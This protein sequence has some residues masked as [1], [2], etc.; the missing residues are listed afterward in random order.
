MFSITVS[1]KGGDEK[2]LEFDK[3]E[4]TIGRV[5]GNDV[6][7]PKGNVSKRHSRIVLKDGKFIIVDLKST[8][9]TY[10]NGRKITSPL[11]VKG[12]DKIYIG[13]F[14]LAID[15]ASDAPAAAP[16]EE[17]PPAPR[18]AATI[19]PPMPPHRPA[20]PDVEVNG[21]TMMASEQPPEMQQLRSRPNLPLP[22]P[23]PAPQAVTMPPPLAPAAAVART[24]MRETAPINAV[25]E[26]VREPEWA[27]APARPPAPVETRPLQPPVLAAAVPAMEVTPNPGT[28]PI[29]KLDEPESETQQRHEK[30]TAFSQAAMPTP[31][32]PIETANVSR[33]QL[34]ETV[35]QLGSELGD[36]LGLDFEGPQRQTTL[37]LRQRA[38]KAARTLVGQATLPTGIDTDLLARWAV[39]EA[40]GFGAFELIME[41]ATVDELSVGA[42]DRVFVKRQGGWSDAPHWFSSRKALDRAIER[43]VAFGG[44][45]THTVAEVQSV[46]LER[47]FE[48]VATGRAGSAARAAVVRRLDVAPH[49]LEE[50]VTEGWLSV[51]MLEL[52]AKAVAGRRNILVTSAFGN[53]RSTLV[54]ALGA[55][56]GTTERIVALSSRKLAPSGAATTLVRA[57]GATLS[58]AL[59]LVPDRLIVDDI[60]LHE[61]LRVVGLLGGGFDG[62]LLSQQASFP[63][64]AISALESMARLQPSA[65]PGEAIDRA[66]TRG[67]HLLA[68]IDRIGSKFR[69][70]ELSELSADRSL[71]TLFAWQRDSARFASVGA[72]SIIGQTQTNPS[73]RMAPPGVRA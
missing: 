59:A 38:E 37:E 24:A 29:E 17:P 54:S 46:V 42:F 32:V 60:Q 9:G 1:E 52:F 26:A 45:P 47:G 66:I 40:A 68:H 36:R 8:N 16:R 39:A 49:S 2:R 30:I 13:D 23:Q 72:P 43:L 21:S 35:A 65:P 34:T 64:E 22:P 48:L 61:A 19:P 14:V 56:A 6:I 15:E 50:L 11:V 10:V 7:L 33:E 73:N 57:A 25:S 55:L 18:K 70:A 71:R 53:A 28:G 20:A 51:E 67:V 44:T 69:V 5:Q 62:L 3:P 58:E 41:D 31:S 12:S 63:S 27:P 4:I